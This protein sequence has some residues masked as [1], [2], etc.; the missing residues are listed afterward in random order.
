MKMREFTNSDWQGYAGCESDTPWMS[1][2]SVKVMLE[3][4]EFTGDVIVDNFSV[5]LHVYCG[6]MEHD[7]GPIEKEYVIEKE[8]MTHKLALNEANEIPHNADIEWLFMHGFRLV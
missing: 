2:D 8:C 6:D 5:S 1:V 7:D 4:Y 3:D